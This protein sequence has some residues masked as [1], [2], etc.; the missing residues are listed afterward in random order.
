[1]DSINLT[2]YIK[3]QS[4]CR[5]GSHFVLNKLQIFDSSFMFFQESGYLADGSPGHDVGAGRLPELRVVPH[6]FPQRWAL[7]CASCA[8]RVLPETRGLRFPGSYL[9]D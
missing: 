8:G 3:V 4:N 5:F 2:V 7:R 6:A 9:L 1:M